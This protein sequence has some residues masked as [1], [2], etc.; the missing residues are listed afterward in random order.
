MSII[1]LLD[2]ILVAQTRSSDFPFVCLCHVCLGILSARIEDRIACDFIEMSLLNFCRFAVG[3]SFD[4]VRGIPSPSDRRPHDWRTK[5]QVR[6]RQQ[7][8]TETDKTGRPAPDSLLIQLLHK[9]I[10]GRRRGSVD[11][12][13]TYKAILPV[14]KEYCLVSSWIRGSTIRVGSG[15]ER[16]VVSFSSHGYGDDAHISQ[17]EMFA[18]IENL[19]HKYPMS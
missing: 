3:M 6:L 4:L 17:R 13:G 10:I 15:E 11:F 14:I 7:L 12:G 8:M 9:V 5:L 16:R 18:P 1:D 19:Q 2:D